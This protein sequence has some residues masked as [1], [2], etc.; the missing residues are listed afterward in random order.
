MAKI[1]QYLGDDGPHGHRAIL[2]DG[3]RVTIPSHLC[4]SVGDEFE[5]SSSYDNPNAQELVVDS[6]VT[7]GGAVVIQ[8]GER[9]SAAESNQGKAVKPTEQPAAENSSGAE[10]SSSI[11]VQGEPQGAAPDSTDEPL[12]SDQEA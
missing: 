7:A 1:I 3:S 6:M 10:P 11:S 4:L 2:S 12:A 9:V 5:E 8:N